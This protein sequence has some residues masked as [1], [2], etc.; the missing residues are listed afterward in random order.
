MIELT[1]VLTDR[2]SR[3]RHLY[4]SNLND[5]LPNTSN[6]NDYLPTA[7]LPGL[8]GEDTGVDILMDELLGGHTVLIA[9][10]EADLS[11]KKRKGSP[12]ATPG[13]AAPGVACGLLP[14]LIPHAPKPVLLSR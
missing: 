1:D 4:T 10:L 11:T 5:Y 7:R 14:Y 3:G 6:L 13:N 2:A 12:Q 9:L 8:L